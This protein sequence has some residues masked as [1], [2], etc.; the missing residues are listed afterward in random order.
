MRRSTSSAR[1]TA[2]SRRRI[3]AIAPRCASAR[4][5]RDLDGAVSFLGCSEDVP[6]L[7]SRASLHCCPSRPEQREAFGLVVLE[8]KLSGLP[9]VVTPSGNL[10]ELIEHGRD[11]WVCPRADAEAL[12]EGLACFLT[13]P[14]A[15]GARP[16]AQRWCRPTRSARRG[17][18]ARGRGLL[19]SGG[20]RDPCGLSISTDRVERGYPVSPAIVCDDWL[21][22]AASLRC[23]L[24]QLVSTHDGLFVL[25]M[26]LAFH[27]MQ[28]TLGVFYKSIDRS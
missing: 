25:P 10:P 20:S 12:A 4:R 22:G 23:G 6:A 15:A 13:P 8:A 18:R 27:W 2:G 1:S 14:D 19:R 21:A 17:S 9:S 28:C 5:A 3:A 7:L 24:L 26:A 16:A 11:G